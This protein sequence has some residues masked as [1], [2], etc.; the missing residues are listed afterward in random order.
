MSVQQLISA[1]L[2]LALLTQAFLVMLFALLLQR[3]RLELDHWPVEPD[4]GWPA[5]EVLLCLRGADE[6][7]PRLLQAL[8]GQR[9]A[10]TWH[11]RVVVDSPADPAWEL[12]ETWMAR[13]DVAWHSLERKSLQQ[14][15]SRGSLKC[16]ALLQGCEALRSDTQ[17]VVLLDAD[18]ALSPD[19]LQCLARA[20][21]Q[22]GVGVVSGNR[23]YAPRGMAVLDWSRA[24]WGAGAFAMMTLLR[25]PW[26]GM[27]ALRRSVV[28]HGAWNDLLQ[29]GLCEDTGLLEPLR[30]MGLRYDFRPELIVVDRSA[31]PGP[32]TLL[33]W[34]TR[35]LLTARL[36]HPAW[37]L[38]MLH[39]LSTGLLLVAA[40]V[41]GAWWAVVIY[42]L[43]CVLLLLAIEALVLERWPHNG[44]GWISGLLLGQ[45]IDA[46]ATVQAQ[47]QR[48][49]EWRGVDYAVTFDPRGV[50]LLLDRNQNY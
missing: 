16:A 41:L 15:P 13:H 35:Q 5:L 19:G 29:H 18:A 43:G 46:C 1:G 47:F 2:L 12:L 50:R 42:E 31:S 26:G 45:L 34:I 49:L 32:L 24:V 33:H 20:C 4:G 27:L 8:A 21:W 10:G 14:V 9:Y 11:L 28:D 6:A 30:Q 36:H 7:L 44:V 25:I 37:P 39:G 38:V 22:P 17:L 3:K 40:I 23:W 48:R